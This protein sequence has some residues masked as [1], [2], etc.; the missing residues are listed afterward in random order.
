MGPSPSAMQLMEGG[1]M[2][3]GTVAFRI[4]RRELNGLC[5]CVTDLAP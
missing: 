2:Q 4:D 5:V 1:C 3:F